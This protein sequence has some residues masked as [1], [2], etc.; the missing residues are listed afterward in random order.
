VYYTTEHTEQCPFGA[1]PMICSETFDTK[2]QAVRYAAIVSLQ[3]NVTVTVR[4]HDGGEAF[5]V[6]LI[7]KKSPESRA[8]MASPFLYP[9]DQHA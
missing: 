3:R 4:L 7:D 5:L 2:K 9:F 6:R 1:G 8:I